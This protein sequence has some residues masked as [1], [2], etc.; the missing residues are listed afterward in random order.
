MKKHLMQVA[1][2][3]SALLLALNAAYAQTSV[4]VYGNL[5]VG[6]DRTT[7][8]EG[9]VQ[10]TV[11]GLK[12]PN[13]VSSPATTV[14]RLT[15]SLS[16]QSYFGFKGTEDLGDGY[17]ANFVL[18]GG[19][20]ADTGSLTSDGRLF[21]RKAY[22]GL[23]TPYGQITLGRQA[24]PMLTSY[25]LSTIERLGTTDLMAAG[26]VI[27]NLQIFQDNMI[28]Y[29]LHTGPWS[30]VVSFSPNAGVASGISSARATATSSSPAATTATGQILGGA[31]AGAE[32]S[33]HRGQ[34]VGAMIGYAM[35]DFTFTASFGRN[36]FDVP[37]GIPTAAGGFTPLFHLRSYTGAMA[38]A[39]YT[40]PGAGTIIAANFHTGEFRLNG[41]V[42]PRVNTIGLGLKQPVGA[43]N[44]S[45][46]YVDQRFT[47]FTK[48]KDKG[49][50]LGIDY[51]LSKRTTLYSR[52][53]FVKDER[54][55]IVKGDLTPLPIAGGPSALLVPLGALETPL[56][57]GAGTNMDA[58]TTI[59]SVGI[60]HT[61]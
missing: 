8:G 50:M 5:D 61:F 46:E 42:N 56:F 24:S 47:N 39:K 59:I 28:A 9:N 7:K 16:S 37:A 35:S 17:R 6:I 21:G 33:S 20:S 11:F 1:I 51:L 22:V 13:S 30:G 45:A 43:F 31:S 2:A 12:G 41:P 57:S 53:G 40:L 52:T 3:H 36:S 38:G 32:T 14:Y 58:R 4:T 60:R 26:I 25:Y 34:T 19:I 15:P 27:N 55:N 49:L 23:A 44:L 54:G 18:E 29:A 48:G 10:N